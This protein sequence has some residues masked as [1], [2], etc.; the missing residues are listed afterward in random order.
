MEKGLKPTSISF[1]SATNKH[2]LFSSMIFCENK[3][4]ESQKKE[5]LIF[6]DEK[7]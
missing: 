4:N 6:A 7:V 3:E 2:Y 5:Y 1:R